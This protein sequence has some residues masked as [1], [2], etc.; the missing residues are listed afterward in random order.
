MN[1]RT[2]AIIAGVSLLLTIAIFIFTAKP[3]APSPAPEATTSATP[4]ALPTPDINQ[5]P[6]EGMSKIT[7][8]ICS[9]T[10]PSLATGVMIVAEKQPTKHRFTRY[11]PGPI[12]SDIQYAIEVAPGNYEIYT[13]TTNRNKI[14]L[15]SNYVI[16]G[17]NP[18]TCVD[19]T[20]IQ[21]GISAGQTLPNIDICDYDWSNPSTLSPLSSLSPTPP[22]TQF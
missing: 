19:H 6:T 14:G 13:E 10:H 1:I 8:R 16:C 22:Q 2:L 20:L 5:P 11:L 15:H 21:I 3:Q 9:H 18:A 17:N 7:G 12:T 4:I